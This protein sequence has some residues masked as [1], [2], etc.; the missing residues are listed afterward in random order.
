MAESGKWNYYRCRSEKIQLLEEELQ[1]ALLQIDEL[2]SKNKALEEHL[3]M[4]ADGKEVGKR[5]TAPVKHE[6]KNCSVL[7]DSILRDVE[8]ELSNMTVDCCRG[9]RTDQLHRAT[10]KR[11]LGSPDTLLLHVGKND[12]RS[13]YLDYVVGEIYC[14][15]ATAKS[16]FP[17]CRLV[18]NGVFGTET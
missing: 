8:T 16:K 1:N 12:L 14:L 4:V 18:L 5:D 7:C 10:E 15:V 9:I 2:K 11:D 17:H 13:R 6:G 3:Q